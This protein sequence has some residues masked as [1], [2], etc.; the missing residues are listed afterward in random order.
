MSWGEDDGFDF[1][2]VYYKILLLSDGKYGVVCLQDFDEHDYTQD[3][4][5][6][7]KD[8]EQLKWFERMDGERK[9]KEFLNEVILPEFIHEDDLIAN[10]AHKYKKPI[11]EWSE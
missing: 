5:L 7:G 8:G 3:N 9:A 11:E 2:P 4:F 10:N 6:R 1:N